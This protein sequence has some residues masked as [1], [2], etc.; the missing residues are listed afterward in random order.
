MDEQLAGLERDYCPILDSALVRAIYADFADN[1]DTGI[2]E[3]RLMLESLKEAALYEQT[4]DFDPSGS[5]GQAAVLSSER[6]NGHSDKETENGASQSEDTDLTS[7][8]NGLSATGLK[9]RSDSGSGESSSM[10][11]NNEFVE[12]AERLSTD[13]KVARLIDTFPTVKPTLISYTLKK[14][15]GNFGRA[16]DELLNHVYFEETEADGVDPEERIVAKGIDAFSEEHALPRGRKGKAKKWKKVG[17]AASSRDSSIPAAPD[18]KSTTN[19]WQSATKDIEF[20]TSRTNLP[21]QYASSMYHKN[22]ASL[23]PTIAALI[24]ANTTENEGSKPDERTHRNALDLTTDFPSLKLPYATAL[25]RLTAPSTASAHE[26]A[27]ALTTAPSN[28][29]T[30]GVELIPKYAPLDLGLSS[31]PPSRASTPAHPVSAADTTALLAAR[32]HAFT[33]ASSAYRRGK[34]DRL[35]L[36]AAGYYSQL[37]R[38]AHASLATASASAADALVASQSTPTTL[39]LHGVDVRNAVRIAREGV[40]A[41]WAGLGEKRLRGSE[42]VGEGF[43]IVTGVGHHSVGGVG[44]LGPAVGRMLVREGW[45]VR[46]GSGSVRVVGAVRK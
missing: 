40:E 29:F 46:F 27:K 19:K 14:C 31:K 43:E 25:I 10:A 20:I 5:S 2:E 42:G 37:G 24:A 28:S 26:L 3:A 8:S 11:G 21:Y 33:S 9:T 1:G 35:M 23:R 12:D 30:G 15:D 17:S 44:R 16:T 39:D 7:L 34:S 41:W 38:D 36:G 32:S 6:D 13:E 22:G 4:T 45:R 18:S